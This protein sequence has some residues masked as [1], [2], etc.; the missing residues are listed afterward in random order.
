MFALTHWTQGLSQYKVIAYMYMHLRQTCNI[1]APWARDM[2]HLFSLCEIAFYNNYICLQQFTA[3]NPPTNLT[4][5]QSGII[6]VQVSWTAPASGG[7]LRTGYR[8]FYQTGGSEQSVDAAAGV[9]SRTLT[10]LLSGMTYNISIESRSNSLPSAVL[11]PSVVRI[12]GEFVSSFHVCKL[13]EAILCDVLQRL[14]ILLLQQYQAPPP[15][16]SPLLSPVVA[17]LLRAI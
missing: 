5:A 8:I 16:E 12:R 6:S 15:S 7:A 9:A 3:A 2:V 4:A 14:R 10:G 11:G 17:W 13:I 1:A